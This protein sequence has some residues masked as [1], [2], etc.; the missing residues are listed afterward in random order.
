[1]KYDDFK[2]MIGKKV[3]V[4]THQGKQYSGF[5]TNTESEFD[6]T[7]G[8]DEIEIESMTSSGERYFVDIKFSSISK[9]KVVE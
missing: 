5:F 4:T 1:M 6:T 9:M 8:E 3:Q 7:S 2:D